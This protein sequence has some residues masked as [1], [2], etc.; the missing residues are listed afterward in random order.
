[1]KWEK[2]LYLKW[3]WYALVGIIVIFFMLAV[4]PLFKMWGIIGEDLYLNLFSES[5][6][7]LFTLLFFVALFELRDFLER[8]KVESKVNKRFGKEI[9]S[10]FVVLSNL[11]EVN[12]PLSFCPPQLYTWKEWYKLRL[13]QLTENDIILGNGK[14]VENERVAKDY[15]RMLETCYKDFSE[16]G[17]KYF[18][19][20]SSE[21][22][23]SVIDIESSLE[24][25]HYMLNVGF[26]YKGSERSLIE[27]MGRLLKEIKRVR[28]IGVDMGF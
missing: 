18:E 11:A 3:F 4:F 24:T 14:L 20:C 26:Y 6:G 25:I 21:L 17:I 28:D 7:L 19:F 27:S 23:S 12:K 1:M 13:E 10:I 22:Q 5:W 16:I 15:S 2:L 9:G 8:K